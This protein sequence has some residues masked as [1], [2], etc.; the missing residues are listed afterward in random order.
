MRV[1]HFGSVRAVALGWALASH[2]RFGAE[3]GTGPRSS[4]RERI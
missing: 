4:G 1:R 2:G 3:R